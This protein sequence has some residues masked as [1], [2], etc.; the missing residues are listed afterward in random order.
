MGLAHQLN[1]PASTVHRILDSCCAAGFAWQDARKRYLPGPK[2]LAVGLQAT[3]QYTFR[4]LAVEHMRRLTEQTCE[5]SYLCIAMGFNGVFI[6]RAPG[7]QPLKI[8]EP[9]YEEMPLHAGATRKVL[10]AYFDPVF[11]ENYLAQPHLKSHT[12]NTITD[13]A[14]LRA[15]LAGVREKGYSISVGECWPEA[16]GIGAPIFGSDGSILASVGILGPRQ[17]LTDEVIAGHV[18]RV[19]AVGRA[20]TEALRPR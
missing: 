16:V 5:E 4:L 8:V 2:L 1:L 3:R 18:D 14:G 9:L 12:P 20:I 15:E 10:L 17:R 19:V 7:P 6:E 13:R 11:Q